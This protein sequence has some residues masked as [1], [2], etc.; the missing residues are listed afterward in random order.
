[1]N[2]PNPTETEPMRR[3]RKAILQL[4]E[5][6]N[7]YSTLLA[8]IVAEI[9]FIR[10]ELLALAQ[11]HP[12]FAHANQRELAEYFVYRL[13][14]VCIYALDVMLIGGF[15]EFCA[16]ALFPHWLF[17]GTTARFL[18]PLAVLGFELG[19]AA[20]RHAAKVEAE[21]AL[22]G[23]P[24]SYS[25]TWWTVL[26]VGWASVAPAITWYTQHAAA[27]LKLVTS[28]VLSRLA[29]VLIVI[30]FILH[31]AVLFAGKFAHDAKG[32]I[33]Y[34]IK[35]RKLGRREAKSSAEARTKR[36]VFQSAVVHYVHQLDHHNTLYPRQQIAPGP[37]TEETK[38]LAVQVF[39]SPVPL[40]I[41][42]HLLRAQR[43]VDS[44]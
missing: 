20:Q 25:V 43:R 2:P 41:D 19:I 30:A 21:D 16:R 5:T 23:A 27:S 12:E 44:L 24:R 32:H 3:S 17:I 36:V 11:Q 42:N 10:Q 22:P 1:M 39:G 28:T 29:P 13:S 26:G 18:T 14:M 7:T 31:I 4:V 6:I 15:A 8:R 40:N 38:S 35:T 37:F 34:W 9:V 33:A